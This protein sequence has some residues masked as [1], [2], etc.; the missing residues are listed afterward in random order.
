VPSGGP[1]ISPD[2]Q[3]IAYLSTS[4]GESAIWIRPIDSLTA[5]QLP[6]TKNSVGGLFWAP[7]SRRLAFFA[8][9]KLKKLDVA[10]GGVQTLGDGGFPAPGAWNR[11]GVILFSGPGGPQQAFCA[12]PTPVV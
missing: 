11:D 4:G 6:G 8:D 1:V 2:G 3:R 5:Q 9:G 10:G 7:D 12:F